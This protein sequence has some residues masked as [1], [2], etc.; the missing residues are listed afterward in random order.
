MLL[1]W[2]HVYDGRRVLLAPP[3]RLLVLLFGG[4]RSSYYRGNIKQGR[5]KCLILGRRCVGGLFGPSATVAAEWS[6]DSASCRQPAMLISQR[7][8]ISPFCPRD[9]PGAA[10][11]TQ[12]CVNG[13]F[14]PVWMLTRSNKT[15]PHKTNANVWAQ[16]SSRLLAELLP[17]QRPA[18]IYHKY[19]YKILLIVQHWAE[20]KVSH[21]GSSNK[22][23]STQ[24]I[25]VTE[26]TLIS[27]AAVV[28]GHLEHDATYKS[29][30]GGVVCIRPEGLPPS[31]VA[32]PSTYSLEGL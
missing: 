22:Q 20:H 5:V 29:L 26:K 27:L 2:L 14:E 19:S 17:H 3:S 24:R 23:L 8:V 11:S 21:C 28:K 25:W 18:Y 32:T 30:L 16:V 9:T 12:A 7:V 4:Q 15:F 31:P 13:P 10:A 6:C 1:P